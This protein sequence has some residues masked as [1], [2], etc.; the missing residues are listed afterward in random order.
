MSI[1]SKNTFAIEEN[2]IAE[3]DKILNNI[4]KYCNINESEMMILRE[5]SIKDL[6]RRVR[7]FFKKLWGKIMEVVRNV[8][9]KTIDSQILLHNYYK[10]NEKI[11]DDAITMIKD[12]KMVLEK[13]YSLYLNFSVDNRMNELRRTRVFD[14]DRYINYVHEY[15]LKQP[16]G[17]YQMDDER[18]QEMIEEYKKS[19]IMTIMGAFITNSSFN[20]TAS[21]FAYQLNKFE[22]MSYEEAIKFLKEFLL[23]EKP[24]KLDNKDAAFTLEQNLYVLARKRGSN[25]EILNGYLD[26]VTNS[27]NVCM[28]NL[29]D[30]ER[31]ITSNPKVIPER[32]PKV[33]SAYSSLF[34]SIFDKYLELYN[35]FASIRSKQ[36]ASYLQ[37]CK[38]L[39]TK[40]NSQGASTQTESALFSSVQFI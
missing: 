36:V 21:D 26:E 38:E 8:R 37:I 11:I 2:F 18:F 17:S 32:V 4:F 15:I 34:K 24:T 40:M 3:S 5:A 30:L 39:V 33:V 28:K 19:S 25:D 9:K 12:G 7:E 35:L 16:D 6:F 27:Y 1:Y 13:K 31:D 29:N 23:K 10:E 22:D 14:F 20:R